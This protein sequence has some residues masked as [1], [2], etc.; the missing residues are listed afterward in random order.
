VNQDDLRRIFLNP[1]IQAFYMVVRKG[2]SSLTD[3]AYSMV[4]GGGRFFDFSKH[5]YAGLSTRAGG[6]AAG[7]SQFIPSTWAELA[8]KYGF[9]GFTREEQDMGYVG[10]LIKRSAV[11]DIMA[12]RFDEAVAKC[13]LEWTSLPGAAENNP[14][15]NLEK[16]RGLYRQFGGWFE[17]APQQPAAPIEDRSTIY[18]PEQ[19]NPVGP[20]AALLLQTILPSIP[21]LFGVFGKNGENADKNTKAAQAVVDVAMKTLGV[22][23]EQQAIEKVTSNPSALKQVATAVMEDPYIMGLTETGSGGIDGARK[24]SLALVQAAGDSPW[25]ILLN[26]VLIVTVLTL[27]L[28]YM[29]M[30]GL[31]PMM[32][33]ISS[34]VV[35]QTIG[36]IIG[37]VLGSI[38]G[39][40]MGQTYQQSK[41]SVVQQE[42]PQ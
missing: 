28:V 4:N 20:F 5:P 23:N 29:I 33:K 42:Q 41:K 24:A 11:E 35:A 1:N 9:T 39:F 34:D 30:F 3:D 13:R 38:M 10:C 27:P 15:W 21:G 36:T 25:K 40:W 18:N 26:P 32:A 16:A 22:V 12:G 31:M 17:A 37:L 7:A 14:S 2:E 6:K 19:E 8:D